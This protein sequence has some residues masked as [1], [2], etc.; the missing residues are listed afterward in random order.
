[1]PVTAV[2]MKRGE[3]VGFLDDDAKVPPE[4]LR[5]AQ[6]ICQIFGPATFGGPYCA[7]YLSPKPAWY[8]DEYGSWVQGAQARCIGENEYLV[9]GNIFIRR[10]IL[11]VLGGFDPSFGMKGNLIR[12]GEETAL[13]EKIRHQQEDNCLYYD[14][15]TLH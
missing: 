8:K 11:E 3:T 10:A 4:W 12:Y 15:R 7:F 6:E 14:P 2:G 1:M 13:I 9:G 5:V